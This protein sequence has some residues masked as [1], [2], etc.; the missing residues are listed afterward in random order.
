[1]ADACSSS[2]SKYEDESNGSFGL[3]SSDEFS[4][5]CSDT[6][7]D[8]SRTGRAKPATL[9]RKRAWNQSSEG[10][11]GGV[12][13]QRDSSFIQG[14]STSASNHGN[15]CFGG[16]SKTINNLI[17]SRAAGPYL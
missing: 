14:I 12:K 13:T 11:K 7:E 4:S 16:K 10:A 1:M 9:S 2:S 3:S 17:Y 6:S 15:R 8:D 5:S